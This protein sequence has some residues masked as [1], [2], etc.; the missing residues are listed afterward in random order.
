MLAVVRKHHTNQPLFEVKGDI[1]SK[2]M[3]Y[4]KNEFGQDIEV[5]QDDEE[6]IDIFDTEWYKEISASTTPGEAL[7]IYREN[8]GLTQAELGKQLGKLSR[9]K[10]S[11]LERGKRNISKEMAKQLSKI[12]RVPVARFL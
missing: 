5:L 12:F 3:Q 11:D 7:R 6:M 2:V 4:L 9:Q 10:I 1:P 8:A